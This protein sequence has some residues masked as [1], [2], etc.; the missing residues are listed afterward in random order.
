MTGP[1][2]DY[3]FSILSPW[4]YIGDT[5]FQ[6]IA[7]RTGAAVTYHPLSSPDLFPAT[8]GQLL[9]DRAQHRKD[10]R[11]A[12]LQRWKD[13]LGIPLNLNPAHFPVPEPPASKLILA[14]Q[15]DGNDAGP[16]LSAILKAVWVDEKNASDPDILIALANDC[17]LDGNAMMT[18]SGD[19]SFDQAFSSCTQNAIAAGVFGY[20]SYIFNSELFWGQDRLDFLERALGLS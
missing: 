14:V 3:Y 19:A 1:K 18:A 12:E 17:G 4:T 2:I 16:L 13:H 9:K 11:M 8:G 15:E 10:Y 7:K 20:P 6:D 5:R